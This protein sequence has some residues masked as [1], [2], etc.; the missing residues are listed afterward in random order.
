MAFLREIYFAIII[1]NTS[2]EGPRL[3][4]D[5]SRQHGVGE[6]PYTSLMSERLTLHEN[7]ER[8]GSAVKGKKALCIHFPSD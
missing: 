8:R 6:R 7:L 5:S 1:L 2:T 3:I 4:T